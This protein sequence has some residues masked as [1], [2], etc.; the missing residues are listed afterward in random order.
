ML[1]LSKAPLFFLVI[2]PPLLTQFFCLSNLSVSFQVPV[3]TQ[4]FF[5]SL[6]PIKF[7]TSSPHLPKLSN[8]S[9]TSDFPRSSNPPKF[10][11]PVGPRCAWNYAVTDSAL[12]VWVPMIAQRPLWAEWICAHQWTIAAYLKF[13]L[14]AKSRPGELHSEDV[15]IVWYHLDLKGLV[16]SQNFWEYMAGHRTEFTPPQWIFLVPCKKYYHL[17]YGPQCAFDTSLKRPM[18]CL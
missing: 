17:R 7:H 14:R 8:L 10:S 6:V 15:S 3:L 2:F 11:K 5:R 18:L 13:W 4:S 1:G 9:S 16:G 12:E